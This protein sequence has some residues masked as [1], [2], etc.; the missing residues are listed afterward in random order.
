MDKRI[1]RH[2]KQTNDSW[3]VDET[4][5]KVKGQ[6]MYLYRAVDS[7][8]NTIDFFLNKTRD[9]KAAKRFL[10]K[11]DLIVIVSSPTIY[12]VENQL[13]LN[14]I[15]NGIVKNKR[16]Y[17]LPANIGA[18]HAPRTMKKIGYNHTSF[19][20]GNSITLSPLLI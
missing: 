19:F 13:Q 1:R 20:D 9:Q 12:F 5:I 8:G 3:R 18:K 7:K 10:T 2:L 11:P 15:A 6:W 4:Y 17:S 16:K 14:S